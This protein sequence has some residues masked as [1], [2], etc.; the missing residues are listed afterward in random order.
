M[1]ENPDKTPVANDLFTYCT[2]EKIDTWHIV[3]N[4]DA[5]GFVERVI[6]KA[7]GSEH[8]YRSA[9]MSAV[10]SPNKKA[11]PK[12]SASSV[13]IPVKT[14]SQLRD[15][16]LLGIKK[17]GAKEVNGFD[18]TLSF[19]SGE[20]LEHKV[21]GKGVVQARRENRVDVLFELGMKTLPSAKPVAV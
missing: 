13:Q 5:K 16:W 4:H 1:A 19:R 10:A 3:R 9:A 12:R 21:F 11:A 14:D 6:C 7:C 20:V 8:K 18:A 17:W 2:R 15:M